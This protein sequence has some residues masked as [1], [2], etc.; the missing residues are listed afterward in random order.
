MRLKSIKL[1]GFKSF[2]DPTTV[3]FPTNLAAVVGPNGCGKS[4]IIDAVRWVMGE[5][6]AKHLRGES[7]TDVIFNGSNGRKPVGQ[8]SIELVFDNSEGKLV[9]EYAQF[10]EISI[11]R[12]VTREAQSFYYLNGIKCRRRDITDLFLGTGLGPRSYAIIEQGMISKLIESKPEELRVFLEEAAGISKYKERRRDTERRMK[13]TEENLE[14]LSDIRDELERQLSHL[15]K[16]AQAAEKYTELKKE[17]RLKNAQ[18]NAVKWRDL[19]RKVADKRSEV[20]ALELALEEILYAR[21]SN[22]TLSEQLR[23]EQHDSNEEFNRVQARY[24]E[25]GAEIARVEQSLQHQKER[26]AQLDRELKEVVSSIEEL[27]E[28]LATDQQRLDDIE[29]EYETL[30][31]ELE[32]SNAQS[33]ESS[34]K[35]AAMEDEMQRWQHDWDQFNQ[36]SSDAR[37]RAE[38]EQ[39]R[40]RQSEQSLVRIGDKA[41]RLQEELNSLQGQ[42]DHTV[43]DELKEQIAEKEMIVEDA[44]IVKLEASEVISASRDAISQLEQQLAERRNTYQQDTGML[45]SK[46]ALQ[47]GALGDDDQDRVNWFKAQ[48]IDTGSPLTQQL[49]VRGGWDVAVEVVLGRLLQSIKV[50]SLDSVKALSSSEVAVAVSLFEDAE[51]SNIERVNEGSEQP[52]T[53]TPLADY[54]D[55]ADF[56]KG[57]LQKVYTAQSMTE[58]ISNRQTLQSDESIVL[59]DGTWVGR[60]WVKLGKKDAVGSGLIQRQKEIDELTKVVAEQREAISALQ[61]EVDN[62][63]SNLQD[64]EVKLET[65]ARNVSDAERALSLLMSQLSSTEVKFEQIQARV[66]R[67]KEDLEDLT[68]QKEQELEVLEESRINWQAAMDEMDKN[69]DEREIQ[70]QRRDEI[71]ASL[72]NYRQQARHQRDTSHQLQLKVQAAKNQK[73]TLS[74]TIYKL[75][76]QLERSNERYQML[77]EN[78]ETNAD[79]VEELQIRLEELLENR[80]GEEELLNSARD[81]L[82]RVDALIRDQERVRNESEQKLNDIRG[83]LERERMDAQA[84]EIHRTGIEEQLTKDS[85]DLQAVLNILPEEAEE[86]VWVAELEKIGNRIQRLGA[87]NL[88][89][90]DEYKVQSERKTYLDAQDADLKEAL[91]T[92]ESAI[93]KID[94]ETRARFKET[95]D[96]VNNGLQELFPKVFGG[97]SAYLDLTGDDLLETGVSIMARPPGKKNSTIHLLSG[98]EKALTA[99][100]LIFSI[101]QLNP[102]PFC[103][104]DEVDAPLDDANVAR[105]ANMVKEMSSQVQFIYI[106]HNKIAMEMADQL[107]G[108]TMHEPGV[109]RLVSVDVEEAAKLASA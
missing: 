20:S 6:S 37:Q 12:K 80:L 91:E 15:H 95:Y 11:R 84:L 56:Y 4:N 85:F 106:T 36:Q 74:S 24:Y 30:L 88:A 92:L 35:L 109:S 83:R 66:S 33:E 96:K 2:V 7:M 70:L 62:A 72:D 60:H 75:T 21:T 68:I 48:G 79:P 47:K 77:M 86:K 105:Y 17:E 10:N 61:S 23:V 16:Q 49:T 98:G 87:I 31:P 58:A 67:T 25:S 51:E 78:S 81:N 63:R 28:E 32:E 108:V 3:P 69:A 64:N 97:G 53:Q 22:D 13:R 73:E 19:D 101:F 100:A 39:S 93:R 65:A 59:A 57:I 8:A 34:E 71:R 102:A 1:A 38:V 42:N 18:L 43:I 54:V 52:T 40:I 26:A 50:P 94:R 99:I 45:A 14:R 89:A 76:L 41:T 55:G 107:M 44:R 9:G 29:I 104:L 82:E 46:V 90:I 103:M 5:S 27:K